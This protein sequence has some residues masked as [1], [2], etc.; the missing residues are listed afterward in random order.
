MSPKR[1]LRSFNPDDKLVQLLRNAGIEEPIVQLVCRLA[2]TTDVAGVG[3]WADSALLSAAG[4]PTLLF[5]PS[6]E[7]AHAAVE[8]VDLASV[9]RCADLYLSVAE[10]FCA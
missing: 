4:I 10:S 3:F 2:G 1:A 8:W 5:G 7:G 9:E 6:G